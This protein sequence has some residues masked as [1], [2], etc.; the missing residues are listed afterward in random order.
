[1]KARFVFVAVVGA[2][3]TWGLGSPALAQGFHFQT[4][5]VH[6]DAGYPHHGFYGGYGSYCRGHWGGYHGGGWN[7]DHV[8]HDTTHLDWHPGEYVPHYNHYHYVPGHW[9]VHYDGHWDHLHH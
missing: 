6:I 9:D 5:G 1:M 8:W 7:R 3:F 2:M 4:H